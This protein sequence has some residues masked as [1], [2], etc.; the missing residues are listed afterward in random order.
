VPTNVLEVRPARRAADG[1]TPRWVKNIRDAE[2]AA[3]SEEPGNVWIVLNPKLAAQII[4]SSPWP[5]K[6]TGFAI[7]SGP[8]RPQI[9]P[10]LNR[11]FERV[12]Y[13]TDPGALLPKDELV[14]ALTLP[15]RSD[16]FIGGM[17]DAESK[18]ATLWRG[19]ITS[20]VV[21]FSAFPPTANGI[22]PNFVHFSVTDYGHT[23]RLGTYEAA[24]DSILYDLDPDFRRWL[25]RQRKAT[26]RTLGASIRRLR[27][28]RQ[29]TRN[30][31]PG[32]DPKT[33]A[34]IE[35]NEVAKPHMETLRIVSQR[36]GTSIDDLASY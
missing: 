32:I 34:R 27:M 4:R 20:L 30:D 6:R 8:L 33:L 36:L 11:R 9:V 2:R 19:D 21:P 1:L 15:D 17:V 22:R 24:S 13:S 25:N 3:A 28:Q 14:E 7:I 23:I 35:R 31:F 26:E 29:L 18:T 16:R 5:G 10:A 12:A